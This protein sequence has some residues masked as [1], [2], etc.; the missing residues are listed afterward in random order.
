MEGDG[1]RWRMKV[2]HNALDEQAITM[3]GG[4]AIVGEIPRGL[5]ALSIPTIRW[6]DLSS[7]LAA[8]VIISL[9]G[10]MEAISIAKAMAVKTGQRLDPNQELIG[11]G[12]ANIIGAA[13]QSYPVSGSFSRSAVNLQAGAV[14]GLSSVVTSVCV[15]IVLLFFTPL[16]YYL[17]QAVLA[18]VIIMA[19][20]GL[21]SV[22]GFVH[23]FRAKK[24]DGIISVASFVFTLAFAPHLD[25]GIMIGVGLSIALFLYEYTRPRV[26]FLSRHEDGS[27]RDS[28]RWMLARCKHILAIRF[29]GKL[30]FANTSTLE[31][32]I[33]EAIATLPDLKHI[34]I[35]ANGIS[36]IDS[37]G[38]EILDQ[39]VD[40]LRDWGY[41]VSFSGLRDPVRDVMARTRLLEKIG[42]ENFFPNVQSAVDAI[43]PKVHDEV[44]HHRCPLLECVPLKSEKYV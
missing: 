5:P 42:E 18:S 44:G 26:T 8:A 34:I 35:V 36:D 28:D 19:V 10:F 39:L 9:L 32:R 13:G 38:E 33:Q 12:L 21:I 4:G 15:A 37:S 40:E 17:P 14:T 20:I 24:A 6:Q 7:L 29:F 2:G 22:S 11:Q 25:K 31:R 41:G 16:L 43:C 30:F 1:N 27:F 23:T 3:S